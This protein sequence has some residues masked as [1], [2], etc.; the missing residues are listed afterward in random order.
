MRGANHSSPTYQ[1]SLSCLVAPLP[2][3]SS[4]TRVR[5][6]D[7]IMSVQIR[8]QTLHESSTG[9][10]ADHCPFLCATGTSSQ[11][12]HEYAV[13]TVAGTPQQPPHGEECQ[14]RVETEVSS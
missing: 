5:K 8:S 2:F 4:C 10:V 14:C 13:H 11:G 12:S 6:R 1:T 7:E 9:R 3:L